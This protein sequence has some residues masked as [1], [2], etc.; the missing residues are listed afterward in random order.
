[1][2]IWGK[3]TETPSH[4]AS[5]LAIQNQLVGGIGIDAL[6][7]EQINTNASRYDRIGTA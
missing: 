4:N 2:L 3:S 7:R 1:M 6:K 5:E